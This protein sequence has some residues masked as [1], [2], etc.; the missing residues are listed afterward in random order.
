M[1]CT[2]LLTFAVCVKNNF[3]ASCLNLVDDCRENK[4]LHVGKL[5]L[6]RGFP[7]KPANKSIP[8]LKSV[9]NSVIPQKG[10][11]QPPHILNE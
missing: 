5:T 7:Y 10:H 9:I 11:D 4:S 8:G 2:M 3:V 6:T 1:L